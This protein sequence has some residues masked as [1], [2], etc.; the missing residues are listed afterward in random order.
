MKKIYSLIAV[1]GVGLLVLC[2]AFGIESV[3]T[4]D[5]NGQYATS[6][7]FATNGIMTSTN[8]VSSLSI[9]GTDTNIGTAGLVI[10]TAAGGKLATTLQ[11]IFGNSF[12]STNIVITS[13]GSTTQTHGLGGMPTLLQCRLIC[14]SSDRSYSVNDEVPIPFN[15]ADGGLNAGV[16]VVPDSTSI[17]IRFGQNPGASIEL[18]DKSGATIGVIDNTKWQFVIRAWK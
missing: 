13:A 2:E 11:P 1:V 4:R 6:S 10:K 17:L 8:T 9:I 3:V 14:T 16:V 12:T 5:S 15:G 18:L 7:M